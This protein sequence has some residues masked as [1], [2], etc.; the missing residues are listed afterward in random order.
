M[1]K[2]GGRKAGGE[3]VPNG[4]WLLIPGAASEPIPYPILEAAAR[5]T[6]LLNDAD[7]PE[8]GC[9]SV[10][11]NEPKKGDN[12]DTLN[13]PK[14]GDKS[15]VK[16]DTQGEKGDN[17]GVP[18]RINQLEPIEPATPPVLGANEPPSSSPPTAAQMQRWCEIQ[19]RLSKAL[20][21]LALK[22]WIGKLHPV[23]FDPPTFSV[24]TQFFAETLRARY[25]PAIEEALGEPALIVVAQAPEETAHAA[26]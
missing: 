25:G 19:N 18:I 20:G 13:E 14:K 21:P 7:P 8:E 23:S 12:G 5:R 16:G 9:Q 2:G 6:A 1:R 4:Y 26:E 3:G 17:Q 15:G 24:T 11:L 10:T 22:D